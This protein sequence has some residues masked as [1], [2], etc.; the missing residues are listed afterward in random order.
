M[1]LN[2]QLLVRLNVSCTNVEPLNQIRGKIILVI[3]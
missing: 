2:M 1:E 3:K